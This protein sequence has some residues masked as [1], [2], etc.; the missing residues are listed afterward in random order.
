MFRHVV[1]FRWS[2]E[3]T[4]DQKDEVATALGRAAGGHRRPSAPTASVPTPPSTTAT[5][6]SPSSPTST[7]W[8]GYLAYRD[9]PAAP[10]VIAEHIAPILTE[11]A[12]VQYPL[13][14]LSRGPTRREFLSARRGAAAAGHWRPCRGQARHRPTTG[15]GS[16]PSPPGWCRRRAVRVRTRRAAPRAPAARRRGRPTRCAARRSATAPGSAQRVVRPRAGA[17]RVLHALGQP[18]GRATAVA[19]ADVEVGMAV[20]HPAEHQR[21]HRQ[22]LLVEEAEPQ[23]AVEAGQSLV[24]AG[25]VDAVGGRVEEHGDVERRRRSPTPRRTPGRR[26]GGRGRCRGTGAR[27]P[28][29]P[30]RPFELGDGAG[31]ILHR[32][33]GEA[34][35]PVGGAATSAASS[36]LWR[37]QKPS[38]HSASTWEK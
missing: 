29:S 30:H 11:R 24:A 16:G 22:R 35:E 14:G 4:A 33:L 9:H 19:D 18:G 20:E 6:T 34:P 1:M 27:R 37:R 5:S 28:S 17:G 26:A 12:A 21:R 38:A 2:P 15:R 13:R 3:A 32:E 10:A 25:P 23:V 36:S 7:T 8:P 31:R